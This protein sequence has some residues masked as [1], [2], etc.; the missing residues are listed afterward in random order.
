MAKLIWEHSP[1]SG[2]WIRLLQG[3][4]TDEKVDAIVNA[5]NS[6]L[7][8]GGGVAGAIVRKGGYAIQEES[9]RVAPVPVGQCVITGAGKLPAKHV[10]HAVGP[11]WGEGNEDN[12]LSNAITN[13]LKLANEKKFKSISFPAI[14][15]GIFGFPKVR[16]VQILLKE[17]IDF[18]EQHPGTSL[19]EIRFCIIDQETA[20]IF[21]EEA[22]K[23]K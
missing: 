21:H 13:S 4:I 22:L 8:H 20:D 7:A 12:K 10:I 16:C 5:A 2:K 15:S 23:L 3:D 11:M 1:I 19:N 9:N 18:Y 14:S 17:T 6:Q